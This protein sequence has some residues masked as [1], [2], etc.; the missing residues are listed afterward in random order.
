MAKS[1]RPAARTRHEGEGIAMAAVREFCA[2]PFLTLGGLC[3]FCAA[4]TTPKGLSYMS[5][6]LPAALFFFFSVA[7]ADYISAHLSPT[8]KKAYCTISVI[9]SA[10][11]GLLFAYAVSIARKPQMVIL[12]SGLAAVAVAAIYV[13]SARLMTARKGALLL[14]ASGFFMRL[15][16]IMTTTIGTKQH[17]AGSVEKMKGHVGYIAYFV[18][19]GRLPEMD[20][21]NVYQ[22][23]HPPLHHITA[24]IW[25]KLQMLLGIAQDHAF[26]NVQLLTLFYSCVCLVLA[27]KIFKA[28]GLR[29]AGLCGATAIIAFCPTFYILSGSINNDVMSIMFML[30]ALLNTLYW[31]KNRSLK[32]ILCIAVCVGCAMMAKLSGWMVAPAIAFI[33]I[34]AMVQDIMAEEKKSAAVKKYAVSFGSF[35]LVSVPLGMWWGIRN[36]IKDGV[37]ITYV[38]QLSKKSGQYVGDIP[39]ATRLFDFNFS[40]FTDVADAFKFYDCDYNEFNPLV[41]LMK[42][43]VFDELFTAKNYP[44]VA[45]IDKF[46]FWAAVAAAAVGFVSMIVCFIAD[47]KLGWVNKVFIGLVYATIIISYYSFCITFPQVCTMNIRYAAPLIVIGAFF[48]GRAA[49][50]LLSNREKFPILKLVCAIMVLCTSSVYSLASVM[51]YENV[52][53]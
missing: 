31:Y 11:F 30:G 20:V 34:T 52:F 47:K 25:V 28:L 2:H 48:V 35:L 29:G 26:E 53:K 21:R 6:I 7:G 24:A 33:F 46:L 23:Y 36:L 17:D 19:N 27:Y 10:V 8:G 50:L 42:T 22:F 38:M 4:V 9:L 44:S 45:V 40:Q 15:A 37:P 13:F 14:M 1:E 16:Y 18:F 43:S 3:F 41:G 12:N 32:R 39:V 51:F 49:Q 5:F